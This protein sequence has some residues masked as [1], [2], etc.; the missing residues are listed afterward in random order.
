[1]FVVIMFGLSSLSVADMWIG[2]VRFIDL[3]TQSAGVGGGISLGAVTE[4]SKWLKKGDGAICW[5]S[6]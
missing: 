1:V 2:R 6:G 3:R 5:G 4:L